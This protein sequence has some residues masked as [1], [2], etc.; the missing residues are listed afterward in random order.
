MEKEGDLLPSFITYYQAMKYKSL[1]GALLVFTGAVCFSSKAIIVKLAYQ[2][3][4]D[5]VSLLALRMLFSLPFFLVIGYVSGRKDK[6]AVALK[7]KEWFHLL[8]LGMV[9]YYLASLFDFQGLQ[10]VTASLERLILFVYPTL[11][12]LITA[13]VHRKPI[14]RNQLFALGLTYIGIFIA[15]AF[16]VNLQG[17]KNIGLAAKY[18]QAVVQAF[19]NVSIIDLNLI[20]ETVDEI[21]GKVSFVIRFMAFFSIITGI[22][23]LIGSVLI[24]KYQ[25]I[26]E[27]VLLRTLGASRRQILSINLLEYLFLGSLAA[28]TGILIALLGSWG[29]AF[30][31]FETPFSPPFLPT[32]FTFLAITA[33]TLLIGLA[34]SR[35]IVNRPPLEILRREV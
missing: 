28:L 8:L 33:L 18:Q 32:L 22:L 11:V 12:V 4:V 20:L 17:Q 9:G 34:N 25:R 21:I 29:L 19:P 5:P 14:E 30:F 35:S 24:S 1:V 6:E 10:Y 26:R 15:F 2:H 3:Q 7:P 16:D 31:Y 27:S 23:V 13:L